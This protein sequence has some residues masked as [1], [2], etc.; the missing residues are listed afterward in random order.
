VK[1]SIFSEEARSTREYTPRVIFGS[2]APICINY[3]RFFFCIPNLFFS[4]AY[5]LKEG[6]PF[7]EE[8][9]SWKVLSGGLTPNLFHMLTKTLDLQFDSISIY[10]GVH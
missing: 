3:W 7:L 6:T 4:W 8:V 5:W 9:V 2:I 10:F 1:Y